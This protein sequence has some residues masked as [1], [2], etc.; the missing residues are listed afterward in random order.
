M[1][2]ELSTA[3]MGRISFAPA[4]EEEEILQNLRCILATTKYSAPLDRSFGIDASFVDNPLPA[5]R[6]K[7]SASVIEAVRTYE[8]RAEVAA[9]SWEGSPDGVLRPKVQVIINGS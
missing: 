1:I 4:T 3:P 7:I 9:I 6:A 2:Y 5:A 8:P